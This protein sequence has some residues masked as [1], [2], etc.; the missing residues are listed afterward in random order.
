VYQYPLDVVLT[1]RRV[2]TPFQYTAFKI[3]LLDRMEQPYRV[4]KVSKHRFWSRVY[5]IEAKLGR[6]FRATRPYP[7][8][9]LDQYFAGVSDAGPAR[10]FPA[11]VEPSAYIPL[12][13]PMDKPEKAPAPLVLLR[14]SRHPKAEYKR[15]A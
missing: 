14:L 7:L 8:Y 9:P 15:A 4:L 10:P 3:H 13:P 1:A 2:L 5:A 6:A 11:R 12:R